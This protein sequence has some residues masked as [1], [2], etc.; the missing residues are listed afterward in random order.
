MIYIDM[1]GVLSDFDKEYEKTFG[2]KPDVAMRDQKESKDYWKTFC[3]DGHF[4][5]LSKMKGAVELLTF[6][7]WLKFNH[8]DVDVEILSSTGGEKYHDTVSKQKTLWLNTYN[9]PY[10]TNFVAGRKKK[11]EYATPSSVLIDDTKDVIEAFTKAGGHGILHTDVN[12]TI[13]KLVDIFYE[14]KR[15]H[16]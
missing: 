15:K 5:K 7:R 9:V 12:K 3:E 6:I 10:K 16:G 4:A 11:A 13:P 14:W 2:V 8:D 1:D